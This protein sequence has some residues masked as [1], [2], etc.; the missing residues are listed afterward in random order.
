MSAL[1]TGNFDISIQTLVGSRKSYYSPMKTSKT[2]S[3]FETDIFV[4]V[5]AI[6]RLASLSSIGAVDN[7]WKILLRTRIVKQTMYLDAACVDMHRPS[8]CI[9]L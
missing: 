1:Q 8:L 6:N 3:T 5:D 9:S 2:L 7:T 4:C